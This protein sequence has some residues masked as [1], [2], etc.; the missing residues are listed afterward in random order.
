MHSTFGHSP[1][2]TRRKMVSLIAA[3]GIAFGS[4]IA[5]QSAAAVET[6]AATTTEIPRAITDV[7]IL[8]D[9]KETDTFTKGQFVDIKFDWNSPGT[10]L[11]AGSFFTIQVPQEYFGSGQKAVPTFPIH[12][13]GSSEVI[14]CGSYGSD[15]T[16]TVVFNEKVEGLQNPRGWVSVG[17]IVSGKESETN[18]PS[19][20]TF[21]DVKSIDINIKPSVGA[22][23]WIFRKDGWL[24]L[25]TDHEFFSLQ[26]M[27]SWRLNVPAYDKELHNLVITD[28]SADPK[29]YFNCDA[30]KANLKMT[31]GLNGPE[32]K[33]I[34]WTLECEKEKVTIKVP[35]VPANRNIVF[36][37]M[38]GAADK[39]VN[40]T[41]TNTATGDADEI[42]TISTNQDSVDVRAAGAADADTPTT[43]PTKPSEPSTPPT[44]PSEPSTPPTK[45]SEPSTPPTKPSEPSTPPTKPSEP[46]TPPTKPSE[47]STPP[48]KPSEPTPPSTPPSSS[49]I[50][51]WLILIPFV[52]LIPLI[53]GG[54]SSTPQVG[55]STPAQPTQP[56]PVKG[57]P[58]T[59]TEAPAAPVKGIE[60]S[61]PAPAATQ[62]PAQAPRKQLAA[63]G[64]NT[65]GLMFVAAL[66]GLAGVALI[67]RKKA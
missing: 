33:D 53:M 49:E 19:K 3:T 20:V 35:T 1:K 52:P 39:L 41:Y 17:A 56:T 38:I 59:T 28:D 46:S 5:P 12:A 43:P 14:G 50:P 10:T 67:R 21:K 16:L 36:G 11:K 60:K 22:A 61:N 27:L 66:L 7:H 23:N 57:L 34:P 13:E 8:A 47:P 54:G 18:K 63:T 64:A 40:G 26:K 30:T 51:W 62:A 25:P 2:N 45:P 4:V 15:G 6:C 65:A 31:E 29:W 55:P 42:K 48:T 58:K 9:G 32:I 44:K 24:T 37:N